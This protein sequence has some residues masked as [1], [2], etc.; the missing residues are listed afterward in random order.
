MR[1]HFLKTVSL[2]KAKQRCGLGR[3]AGISY[4]CVAVEKSPNLSY[5]HL[6]GNSSFLLHGP[7]VKSGDLFGVSFLNCRLDSLVMSFGS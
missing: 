4:S 6:Q 5:P 2:E 1:F 7:G 3:L